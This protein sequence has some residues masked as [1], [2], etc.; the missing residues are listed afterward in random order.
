[1]HTPLD[2][3]SNG[4]TGRGIHE[5]YTTRSLLQW[6]DWT[7]ISSARD[8]LLCNSRSQC[9]SP[10][11]TL[12][13]LAS[14]CTETVPTT[15]LFSDSL[16]HRRLRTN[17]PFPFQMIQFTDSV[18]RTCQDNAS[19]TMQACPRIRLQCR[20]S[21]SVLHILHLCAMF[22]MPWLLQLLPAASNKN[23]WRKQSCT[24]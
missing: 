20:V 10:F 4:R 11:L 18:S 8:R 15:S 1:M 12:T 9:F 3:Y 2:H 21:T 17:S 24:W 14:L 13:Q 23:L 6:T 5:A 7:G 19:S 16:P 22:V